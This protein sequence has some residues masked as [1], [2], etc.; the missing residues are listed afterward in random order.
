VQ[1][2]EQRE[3]DSSAPRTED[4]LEEGGSSFRVSSFR[5]SPFW[6]AA[7]LASLVAL[8]VAAPSGLILLGFLGVI[9]STHEAGH[10]VVARRAG[11]LPTEY[12][13]GFGPEVISFERNGCRYGVKALFLGGYVKLIGMTPSSDIPEG[14][15]EAGT[16]RAASHRGR[17]NTILAGPGV[18]IVM[19]SIAFMIA[20]FLEGQPAASALWAGVGDVW[21]VI[22]GTADAL[23]IWVSNIGAYSSSLFD[24][25]GAS[26]APVR[27]MSPVAQAKVSGWALENGVVTSLRW[28]AILSCAVGVVNLLPL[29]PLD[30]SHAAV[31]AVEGVLSKIRPGHDARL[32]V[33]RLVPVAYATLFVLVFLSV[34]ALVLDLRDII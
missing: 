6:A 32:D 17:L 26:E 3:V 18:N 13:W 25:S 16:Y 10:L 28:F 15:P 9:V 34:S 27:F 14:F 2:P 21:F 7:A 31:A 29:P 19:A 22:S 4:N 11:M 20:A 5:V 30:G 1:V 23:W 8:A 33:T 24:S 12:F